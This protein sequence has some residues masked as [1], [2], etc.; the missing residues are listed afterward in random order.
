MFTGFPILSKKLIGMLEV[1]GFRY[2]VKQNFPRG[3]QYAANQSSL[4][5]PFNALDKAQ[6]YFKMLRKDPASEMFDIN[7]CRQKNSLIKLS[8]IPCTIS[9]VKIIEHYF[10]LDN[11][12]RYKIA[13]YVEKKYPDFYQLMIKK[14]FKIVIGD[15]FGDVFFKI[16]LAKGI[17]FSI[18]DRELDNY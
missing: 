4:F 2:F 8:E 13:T 10:K 16:K 11:D 1:Q 18:N 12:T 5:S 14:D 17:T 15:N 7:D 6:Y 3:I 9:Y